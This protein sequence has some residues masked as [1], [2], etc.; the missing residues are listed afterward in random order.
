MKYRVTCLTPTLVGDGQ[1]LS[2]IDYMVWKDQVNVLDQRRIFKLLAKGPRLDSY[3]SQLKKSERLDFASWGGFAQNFAGRRIPFEHASSSAY[4]QKAYTENLFIPTFASGVHGPYLPASAIKGVLRTA[5]L[6]KRWSKETMEEAA[7]RAEGERSLRRVTNGAENAL[8][9]ASGA[10]RMKFLG[11][12]DSGSIANGAFKVYLLRASTMTAKGADRFELGWKQAPRGT[13]IRP[14]DSTPLFAEM[15]VPGTEFS[16]EWQESEFLKRPE[17]TRALHWKQPDR[18]N[19]FA[20][21]ND[22]AEAQLKMHADYATRLGLPDVA[23]SIQA[24]E[25]RLGE[26]RTAGDGCLMSIGYGGGFLS[27][28]PYLETTDASYRKILGA[29]P[30]FSRAIQSG[31]PFPKTRRIVFLNNRPGTL[32]GWVQ[33]RVE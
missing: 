33:L 6:F 30:F 5:A 27:K 11:L 10:D 26:L 14:E 31:L 15:A 13:A 22:Y 17:V 20:A 2:P 16:G 9:G 21:A 18:A 29:L 12:A 7:R 19:V 3:L 8:L 4:W 28:A 24:L 25:A 32:A 1:K 23:A